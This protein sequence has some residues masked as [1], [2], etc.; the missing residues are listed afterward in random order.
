M[1]YTTI[2]NPSEH[3]TTVLTT[4]TGSAITIDTGFKPDWLWTKARDQ[5]RSHELHDTNRGDNNITNTIT[6]NWCRCLD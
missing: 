3:F 2:D 5:V 6:L 1:A 4:S